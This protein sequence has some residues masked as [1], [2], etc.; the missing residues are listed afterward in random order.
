MRQ[1]CAY[2]AT[3]LALLMPVGARAGEA[4]QARELAT[5]S[6]FDPGSSADIT[7]I[8]APD[9]K[10]G[11]ATCTIALAADPQNAKLELAMGR[12]Q[13]AL[14]DYAKSRASFEASTAKG[15]AAA[16]NELAA[17]Y[18]LGA[19]GL[20]KNDL[21]AARL[22]KLAADQANAFG[23]FNLGRFYAHGRG[24]LS[25]SDDE[26]A[27]LLSSLPSRGCQSRNSTSAFR[28]T[29]DEAGYKGAKVMLRDFTHS[30]RRR[31]LQARNT[32]S[33]FAIR[34]DCAV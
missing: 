25:K 24:G 18:E 13:F 6:R 11:L 29:L 3:C 17:F 26:A 22:Y 15:N 9:P 5:A 14:R 21:E 27:R 28:M 4:A 23:Q 1:T 30:P 2:L 12:A 16:A 8:S 10:V 34:M 20:P 19:G 31:D 7:S 32:I 33:A